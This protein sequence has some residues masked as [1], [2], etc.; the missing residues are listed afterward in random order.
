[1]VKSESLFFSGLSSLAV[2]KRR[3]SASAACCFIPAGMKSKSN[4]DMRRRQPASLHVM[5]VRLNIHLIALWSVRI[6]KLLT[7]RSGRRSTTDHEMAS[8]SL[9]VMSNRC[10]V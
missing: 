4:F 9:C 8:N 5:L 7:Q 1:M 10:S 3:S 6:V 2:V